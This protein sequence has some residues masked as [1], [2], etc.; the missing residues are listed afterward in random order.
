[1]KKRLEHMEVKEKPK[2]TARIRPEFRLY[3]TPENRIL[4]EGEHMTFSY[5]GERKLFEDAG[6]AIQNKSRVAIVGENGAG[7]T[8]LLHLIADSVQE[9]PH[10]LTV[11]I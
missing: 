4:I 10:S 3:D 5:D 8:T 1:M 11:F 6:F 7:K 2:E 9:K